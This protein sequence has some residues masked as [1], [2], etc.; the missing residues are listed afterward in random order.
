M[1]FLRTGGLLAATASLAAFLAVAT[2]PANAQQQPRQ[3]VPAAPATPAAP[4]ATTAGPVTTSIGVVD[5]QRLFRESA[6]GKA[7]NQQLAD[8]RARYQTEVAKQEER[9]RVEEAELGRA[10]ATLPPDQFENKRR[11]LQRRVQDT[12]RTVQD[13]NTALDSAQQQARDQILRVI[14]EI[15]VQIMNERGYTI[16]LDQAQVLLS[17]DGLNMT[18]DALRRLDQKLPTIRIQPAAPQAANPPK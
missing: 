16:V 6:A 10:R 13:R 9:L 5:I 17:N 12:Q 1:R 2:G 4:A 14:Q 15:V 11:E 7:A 18:N 8:M 3:T